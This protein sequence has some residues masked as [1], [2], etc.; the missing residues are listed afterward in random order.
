V[1]SDPS[2][3]YH[4]RVKMTADPFA[5]VQE[6][7]SVIKIKKDKPKAKDKSKDKEKAEDKD[8]PKA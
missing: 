5:I 2:D 4:V 7:D 1:P 6:N 8:K 3:E